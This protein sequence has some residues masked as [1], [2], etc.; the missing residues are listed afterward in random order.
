MP[1]AG[2]SPC[3]R[4]TL[5]PYSGARTNR[6]RPLPRGLR[7]VDSMAAGRTRDAGGTEPAGK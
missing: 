6:G 5:E 1:G 7:G 3:G 4:A 2:I